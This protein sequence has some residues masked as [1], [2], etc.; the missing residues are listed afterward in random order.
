MRRLMPF[1]LG[2]GAALL[3]LAGLGLS[4]YLWSGIDRSLATTLDLAGRMLPADQSLD[5]GEVEGS[6]RSGGRIGWL[7]WRQGALSVEARDAEVTWSLA[8]LL[9]G[10]LRLDRLPRADA[11]DP[12]R[13]PL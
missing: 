6:L 3:V 9:D 12:G 4:L 13:G 8:G 10:Q 2:V 11:A 5:A 1:V 7:R